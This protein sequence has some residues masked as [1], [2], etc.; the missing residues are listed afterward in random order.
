[1]RFAAADIGSNAVRFLF[2]EA[3]PGKEESL[4]L[5]KLTLIRLPIRLGEDVFVSG[6]ISEE[7]ADRLVESFRAFRHL[8][9]VYQVVEY[10][11]CATSAFREAENGDSIAD[12]IREETGVKIER[13]GGLEEASLLYQLHEQKHLKNKEDLLFVDVGGGSTEVSVI[14]NKKVVFSHSFKIGTLRIKNKKVPYSMWEEMEQKVKEISEKHRPEWMVATGGNIYRLYRLCGLKEYEL[15]SYKQLKKVKEELAL[16]TVEERMRKYGMREDR[17]DVI[18][19]AADIYLSVA[20]HAGIKEIFVPKMG[21]A[22]GIIYQLFRK[23][24]S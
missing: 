20:K 23:H 6:K 14:A 24:T 22:D 13:I 10:R 1:M 4:N 17:A 7:L 8:C 16:L 9:R 2:S 5:K 12:K 11:C 18:V 21:L 19:Y 15:L 3:L